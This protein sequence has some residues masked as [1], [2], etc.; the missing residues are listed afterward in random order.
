MVETG[1]VGSR[2]LDALV[3]TAA[4]TAEQVAAATE[5]AQA[6]GI[7][8]GKWLFDRGVIEADDIAIALEREL[9]VPHVDLSSYSPDDSA[10]ALVPAGSARDYSVLPLFE[11]DGILTVAIG[12]PADMFG[13][14]ALATELGVELEAVLVEPAA[15]RQAV[16]NH[17][18]PAE[19]AGTI[20][21][22]PSGTGTSELLE[23]EVAESGTG[24]GI[25]DA[26]DSH[27]PGS[28]D[29]AGETVASELERANG[30]TIDLD[31]LAVADAGKVAVLVSD[32]LADALGRRATAIHL[33]PYKDDFFL[34]YRVGGRLEQV[35]SAPL[36]LQSALA[37]GLKAYVRVGAAAGVAP[38]LGR[39][40]TRIAEREIVLTLSAVPTVSGQR[41][42]V[43]LES[44][45]GA[46]RDLASLGMPEAET[47]ALH[48]MVERGRGILLVCAPVAGG[49]SATYYALLAHAAGAGKTVY[50]VEHSVDYEIPAVSQVLVNPGSPIGAAAYLEAGMR[51]DTDLVALDS[52]QS[53]EDVHRAI[54]AA[55]MGKLVI[56]TFS[57]AGIVAGVRR[58]LDLGAEPTS[59]AAALTF[60]VGQ[61]LVRTICP[62]CSVEEASPLARRIPDA[63]PVIVPRAGSGCSSCGGTGFGGITGVF[64]VLPFTESVRAAIA[65]SA[66]TSQIAARAQ[67]AGM[68]PMIASGL[69]KLEQGLV[70]AEELNRVLRFAE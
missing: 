67:A 69:A 8:P 61:R 51:Q 41:L 43:S 47:R 19:A 23:S 3:K 29:G 11:I 13:L 21:P 62:D 58:M 18:G 6:A 48:A 2:V 49:R 24:E 38:A 4:L 16:L 70:S 26:G 14:D 46:P 68:R 45:P 64:E 28:D 22:P 10:L 7:S 36:S 59:L 52:M 66:D 55:G 60:G 42:V 44:D 40:R 27:T 50:S 20:P 63:S 34:V 53:V 54:E 31:V 1:T 5:P 57:G 37:D 9:G 12:E 17:F 39:V 65:A 35:A 25:P 56:A 30:A 33:L 15:L 32:I